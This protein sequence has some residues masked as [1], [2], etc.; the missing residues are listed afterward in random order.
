ML[1]HVT[2]HGRLTAAPELRKTDSGK[3]VTTFTIAV[4]RDKEHTDFIPCVAWERRAEHISAYFDRGQEAVVS[5]RIGSRSY[6]D[7]DGKRRTA[8]E[9]TVES[10]DFCGKKSSTAETPEHPRYATPTLAEISDDDGE[11][12]F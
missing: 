4:D 5:G 1:N 9:V 6:Q 7:K 10:I 12:P 3:S 8:Y 11:L 2:L